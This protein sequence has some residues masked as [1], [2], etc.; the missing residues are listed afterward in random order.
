MPGTP[1]GSSDRLSPT[2]RQRYERMLKAASAQRRDG[3]SDAMALS[4]WITE[5]SAGRAAYAEDRHAALT[6]ACKVY[7]RG[8]QV[9][10]SSDTGRLTDDDDGPESAADPMPEDDQLDDDADPEA[11]YRALMRT[12]EKLSAKEGVTQAQAFEKLLAAREPRLRTLVKCARGA[13][14]RRL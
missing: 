4:R 7:R 3:E 11:A 2:A 12:A 6:E 13:V 8:S 14:I 10:L 1:A 5:T 9:A